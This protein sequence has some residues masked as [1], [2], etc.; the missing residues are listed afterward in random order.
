MLGQDNGRSCSGYDQ[1]EWVAEQLPDVGRCK[2]CEAV[3][4]VDLDIESKCPQKSTGRDLRIGSQIS[5]NLL[6]D[7]RHC[8]RDSACGSS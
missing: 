6:L 3:T 5:L 1:L 8:S 4:R 7:A 2:L